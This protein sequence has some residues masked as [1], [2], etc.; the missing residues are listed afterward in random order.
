MAQTALFQP[1][2]TTP[3]HS[4]PILASLGLRARDR[5]Q[6]LGFPSRQDEDWRLTSL[7]PITNSPFTRAGEAT[8]N[9]ENWAFPGVCTITFV[10]D[11]LVSDIASDDLPSGLTVLPLARAAETRPDLIEK[12]LGKL[13][14]F[15][16]QPFVALNTAQGLEGILIHF[17]AGTI[18][19]RPLNIV[20]AATGD[21]TV[22]YPRILIVGDEGSEATVVETHVGEGKT[23]TCPVTEIVVGRRAS[24]NHTRLIE[25]NSQGSCVG[26]VSA[27]VERDGAY[28]LSSVSLG[29]A[30]ART[31]IRVD[32]KGEFA[33]ATLDGLTLVGGSDQGGAHVVVDHQVPN[34][35][36][37]QRFRSVLDDR[38]KAVFTGRI[39]VAENAQ[40]TDARQSS[41][42][43]LRSSDAVAHNNPQLEI[44]ADDVRCT[45]G[46]TVGQLNEEA[47]FYLRT[48]GIDRAAAK[49]LLTLAFAAEVVGNIPVESVRSR[50]ENQLISQLGPETPR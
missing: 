13:A 2:F 24:V 31:D 16:D 34:C 17:A 45:H 6:E 18:L 30:L 25:L 48:R 36:S 47:L 11:R 22:T 27:S 41:K 42:S 39:I 26:T 37:T 49:G 3:A 10:N 32:L 35:T 46:S 14:S 5:F 7:T 44:Y 21:E 40:K 9:T 23:L 4:S 19:G 15:D 29:G 43:L 38:S 20:Y 1:D 50:L 12:H 8:L 33:D 28:H